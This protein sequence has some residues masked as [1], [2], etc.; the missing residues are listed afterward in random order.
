MVVEPGFADADH[1]GMGGALDQFVET[2]FG[3]GFAVGMDADGGV[4]VFV[5]FG[6]GQH[7]LEAVAADADG[8]RPHHIVSAHIGEHFVQALAQAVEIKVAVGVDNL[9]GG[10]GAP[11]FRQPER[12][13]KMKNGALCLIRR[14][15]ANPNPRAA[16][17]L[18]API[19]FA[20][21]AFQAACRMWRRGVS[22]C[23]LC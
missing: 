4:N 12:R 10:L 21:A 1:F 7:L 17:S 20:R 16:G 2:E 23:L 8:Q 19:R 18:K 6:D 9:H 5:L 3:G 11:P 15:P 22:G 13:R 14:H